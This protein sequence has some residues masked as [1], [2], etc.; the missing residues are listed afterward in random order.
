MDHENDC[1]ITVPFR[2]VITHSHG[3]NGEPNVVWGLELKMSQTSG[4]VAVN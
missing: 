3:M 2:M 4:S 1:V